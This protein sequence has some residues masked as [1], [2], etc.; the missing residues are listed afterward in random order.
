MVILTL[1]RALPSCVNVIALG[2]FF[3]IIYGV[4]GVQLF[5]G[6]FYSCNDD[7]VRSVEVRGHILLL[8][9]GLF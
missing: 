5:A 8:G 4:L 9:C 6:T 2:L 3:F 7:S 1:S